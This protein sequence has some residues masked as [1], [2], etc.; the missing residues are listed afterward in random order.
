MKEQYN[1]ATYSELLERVSKLEEENKELK[2]TLSK[3]E[4]GLADIDKIYRNDVSLLYNM[5]AEVYDNL[6][7]KQSSVFINDVLP[8]LNRGMNDPHTLIECARIMVDD[9]L[10]GKHENDESYVYRTYLEEMIKNLTQNLNNGVNKYERWEIPYPT[11]KYDNYFE[12]KYRG[13]KFKT[14]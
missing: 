8:K 3:R 10:Y 14:I 9:L 11:D 5:I 2:E 6:H 7:S 13:Y 4:L 12:N 1:S